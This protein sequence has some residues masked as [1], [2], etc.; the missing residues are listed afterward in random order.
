[1]NLLGSMN[2]LSSAARIHHTDGVG[3][4]S[5]RRCCAMRVNYFSLLLMRCWLWL[6]LLLWWLLLLVLLVQLIASVLNLGQTQL[7]IKVL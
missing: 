3:P 5:A 2:L 1:M 4:V 7:S 6:L